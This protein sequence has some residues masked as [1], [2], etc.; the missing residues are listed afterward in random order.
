MR[1]TMLAMFYMLLKTMSRIDAIKVISNRFQLSCSDVGKILKPKQEW[2]PKAVKQVC[3]NTDC[4]V[5]I[6]PC[7]DLETVRNF[8]LNR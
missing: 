8:F 2:R 5:C 3:V 7:K 6:S 4:K 1:N